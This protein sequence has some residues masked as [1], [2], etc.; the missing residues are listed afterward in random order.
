MNL[1]KHHYYFCSMGSGFN[2]GVYLGE[3]PRDGHV[4]VRT[5]FA[6]DEG[7]LH[8]TFPSSTLKQWD[9][10]DLGRHDP[11]TTERDVLTTLSQQ[12]Y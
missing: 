6:C 11:M 1:I 7:K 5:P 2:I 10:F 3:S 8:G 12:L 9:L 4:F